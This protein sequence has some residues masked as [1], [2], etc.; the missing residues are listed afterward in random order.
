MNFII[1]LFLNAIAVVLTAY[2]LSSGV[3]LQDFWYA[4]FLAAL[5]SLLN[6]SVKPVLVFLTIPATIVSLGLFLLV[7]NALIIEIAAWIL[8]PGF[9]VDSFWWALLFSIL[10]S[11]I[12]SVFERLTVKREPAEDKKMKIFDKDGNQIA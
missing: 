9:R 5:L 4:L 7:I 8:K 2:L 3:H 11:I 10:L 12:N 6:V 1:K